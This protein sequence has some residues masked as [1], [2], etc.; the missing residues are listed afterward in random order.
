MNTDD[1]QIGTNEPSEFVMQEMAKIGRRWTVTCAVGA[2]ASIAL[3]VWAYCRFA[4]DSPALPWLTTAYFLL[5]S[6]WTYV[7]RQLQYARASGQPS[8]R[9]PQWTNGLYW[10]EKGVL[11]ALL[12]IRWKYALL[13]YVAAYAMAVFDI[14]ETVGGI[15]IRRLLRP[16]MADQDQWAG[17]T[18]DE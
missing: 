18:G 17:R 2:L 9:V 11:V 13:L 7:K 1:P 15:M 12:I 16:R 14:L 5:A 4:A 8:P 6:A 10:A 3:V